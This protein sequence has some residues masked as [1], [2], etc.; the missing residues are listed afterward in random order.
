MYSPNSPELTQP[1]PTEEGTVKV[2][3]SLSRASSLVS[4]CHSPDSQNQAYRRQ[5]KD[6]DPPSYFEV[7]RAASAIDGQL[8]SFEE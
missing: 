2:D 4:D 7:Q 5:Y 8:A 3:A 6:T 1:E